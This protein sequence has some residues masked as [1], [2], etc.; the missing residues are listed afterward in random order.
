MASIIF[1]DIERDGMLKGP[2]IEKTK[3]F[4]KISAVPIIASGGV[5][6]LEDLKRLKK[7]KTYGV[8]VG[9]ALYENKIK[10]SELFSV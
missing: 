6:S 1:T 4:S 3:E 5:A 8:I 10:L 2:N 9:K 7:T